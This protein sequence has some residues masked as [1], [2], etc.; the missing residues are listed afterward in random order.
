MFKSLLE[1]RHLRALKAI[2]STGSL[3]KAADLMCLTQSAVSHQVKVL[4][5]FYGEPL[6]FKQAGHTRFTML[7]NRLLR[8]ATCVLPQMEQAELDIQQMKQGAAGRLRIAVEC[9]TCFDW[10][11]PAMDVY[12]QRWPEVE[13][14]IVS[15]FHSDPV[16]L[17]HQGDAELAIVSDNQPEAGVFYLP[18][19]RY[20]VVGVV[21]VD[22][23]LAAKRHL[24]PED[25]A[26]QVLIAYPVPEEMLDVVKN[27]LAP[28]GVFPKR[29][30]SELTIAL[31][32]LVASKRGISALPLWAVKP[33]V[34]KAYV[35]QVPLGPQGLMASLHA[36]MPNG[37]SQKQ[38]LLD[39]VFVMRE[40]CAHKLDG[41]ELLRNPISLKK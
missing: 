6:L 27:F 33:Y 25:F 29:R 4:E 18:L 26:D 38:Y 17:L 3:S 30:S 40:V 28:A 13:L 34:E 9:H 19:F 7:G 24:V 39:F 37:L 21:P 16:G 10:L 8:L 23:E 36:A 41:V 15:G 12:R 22:S 35:A 31:L 11:M 2:E 1:L 5:D 32:Q 14:D 20:E